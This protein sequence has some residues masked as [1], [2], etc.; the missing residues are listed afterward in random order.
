MTDGRPTLR[1]SMTQDLDRRT[2][3]AIAT[4]E[5]RGGLA[6]VRLSGSEA[7]DVARRVLPGGELAVPVK[8]H[9]AR[10]A[11]VCWPQDPTLRPTGHPSDIAGLGPGAELDQVMVL[12]LLAPASYTGE[13]TVE[14]FCHGGMMPARLVLAACRA[15]GARAAGA[16]EFTRRAL[17]KGRLSLSE[18][19]AVS[20]LIAAENTAGARA[21]LAQLR[22]GLGRAVDAIESPLRQ[23][24]A[25]IEGSLEFEEHECAGPTVEET[26]SVLGEAC[27]KVRRLLSLAPAGRQLR[28]GVHVVLAGPPNAGKSSLFNALLDR[29]RALVDARPGTT[30]DVITA[31]LEIDGV[32]F[33]LHDTAGVR[34]RARGVEAKGVDLTYR[35]MAEADIVLDLRP[36]DAAPPRGCA[37][38]PAAE[39]C[40]RLAV[41]TKGDLGSSTE[42]LVTSSRTGTGIQE[43]KATLLAEARKGGLD[44]AISQGVLLNQRHQDRLRDCLVQ[45]D[46]LLGAER[47]AGEVVATMLAAILQD[48]GEVSGRVF[49]E[50][51]LEEVFSRF[52][53]GK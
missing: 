22:G 33:V 45:L 7:L 35:T 19:E 13:D 52:C 47:P 29:P 25:Q 24:L 20:D 41:N 39:G 2:I 51:L 30:R 27:E 23:L 6:V 11:R 26:R 40:L 8:S 43:L 48:L 32:L 15:A 18:A 53:V 1:R 21:A 10:L 50:R 37:L 14:F 28:E 12:P 31:N 9:R 34:A 49:N 5:G 4:P 36:V 17:L 46:D 16:G 42:A 3:V 44:S 38:P